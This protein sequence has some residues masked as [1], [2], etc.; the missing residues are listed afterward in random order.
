M[1]R[2]SRE[3]VLSACYHDKAYV[4]IYS[5]SFKVFIFWAKFCTPSR[6]RVYATYVCLYTLSQTFVWH[7]LSLA[8][9][10]KYA[11]KVWIYFFVCIISLLT[12]IKCNFPVF[13]GGWG[14]VVVYTCLVSCCKIPLSFRRFRFWPWEKTQF[15]THIGC[16]FDINPKS[17]ISVLEGIKMFSNIWSLF[18]VHVKLSKQYT[19]LRVYIY[20][21]IYTHT[22]TNMFVCLCNIYWQIHNLMKIVFILCNKYF[23]SIFLNVGKALWCRG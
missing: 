21:Y 20:I 12:H 6:L 8:H 4:R 1:A 23:N 16:L 18:L 3:S 9:V 2:G 14:G 17:T 15:P 22:H 7:I 10:I 11:I 13:L 19:Y 5:I